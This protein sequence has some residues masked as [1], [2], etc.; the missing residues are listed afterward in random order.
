[1]YVCACVCVSACVYERTRARC[2]FV[3]E[4]VRDCAS[5]RICVFVRVCLRVRV[6]AYLCACVRVRVCVNMCLGVC[7]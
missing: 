6:H 1:M 2:V 4:C 5:N 3:F 7:A